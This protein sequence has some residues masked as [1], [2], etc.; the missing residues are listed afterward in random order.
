MQRLK[1]T[2]IL[3]VVLRLGVC[4]WI[5]RIKRTQIEAISE[6]GARENIWT[7]EEGSNRRLDEAA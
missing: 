1:Y 7:E 2:I 3:S 5:Y 4:N 6:R